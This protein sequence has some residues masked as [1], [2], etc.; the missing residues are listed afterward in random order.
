MAARNAADELA[1]E[2]LVQLFDPTRIALESVSSHS[3]A[4]EVMTA[5]EKAAPDLLCVVSMP[6]GGLAQARYICRRI[7][8]R[9]PNVRILVFRPGAHETTRQASEKLIEDDGANSVAYSFEDALTKAEQQL[10]MRSPT[11]A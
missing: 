6:P 9:M 4:S 5:T 8:A 10:A 1:W 11:P 7:R 3:L 2:M